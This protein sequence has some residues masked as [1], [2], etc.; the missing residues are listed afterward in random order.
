VERLDCAAMDEHLR[1]ISRVYGPETWD[2]YEQLDRSLDPRNPDTM[3][4]LAAERL[5]ADS[6]VLDVGCRDASHL[7]KL[8]QATGA[9][10]VGIDPLERFV[11]HARD[12]VADAGLADRVHIAQGTMQAIP[13][14][15]SS[16]DLV[17]CRDVIEVV[18][19][20]DA[21]VA[22]VAR[23][24][25]QGACVV[26]YT[27]LAG[28]RLEPADAALLAQ[29]LTLVAASMDEQNVEAAF[30]RAGLTVERK[31]AIGTEWREH[32]EERTQPVSRDLLRLARL[33]RERDR[34]VET[35]GEEIYGH[36]E[37][38]LHWGVYQLLG[39][40]LPTVYVLRKPS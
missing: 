35:A 7:M 17:W 12:A 18:E 3:L 29:N 9:R 16:F 5:T 26:A 37:S 14:D 30:A 1:A 36:I 24:L 28:D 15:D 39:K 21:A 22:E 8:V 10:G 4:A 32:L 19:H 6:V 31:D 33:R 23:V 20:L 11:E 27:V 40:L 2:V 34:I 25:R 13:A 38:N